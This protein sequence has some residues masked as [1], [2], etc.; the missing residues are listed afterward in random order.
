MQK[1]IRKTRIKLQ[2][3]WPSCTGCAISPI[4]TEKEGEHS[5]ISKRNLKARRK[6]VRQNA[7]DSGNNTNA[8]GC[9]SDPL[10]RLG[11]NRVKFLHV[12]YWHVITWIFSHIIWDESAL[13]SFSKTIIFIRPTGLSSLVRLWKICLCW[14]IPNCTR[15]HVITYT[16]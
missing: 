6:F 13:E 8:S 7:S 14:F 11:E 16:N 12:Y 15:N 3:C 5:I 10:T 1:F 2:A 9:T 4:V